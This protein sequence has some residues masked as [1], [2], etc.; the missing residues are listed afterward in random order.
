MASAVVQSN[1]VGSNA[2]GGPTGSFNATLPGSITQN[3]TITL[4]ISGD[5][6]I[7]ND[8]TASGWTQVIAHTLAGRQTNYVYTKVAGAGES[9]SVTINLTGA[10]TLYYSYY[11]EERSGLAV[12]TSY[13]VS[14]LHDDSTNS[15]TRVTGTTATTAQAAEFILT[16]ISAFHDGTTF[17]SWAALSPASGTPSALCTSVGYDSLSIGGID[18]NGTG[19]YFGTANVDGTGFPKCSAWI[20]TFL[21]ASSSVPTPGPISA[22]SQA[23]QQA[24]SW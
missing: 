18:V 9:N 21:L 5:G 2:G 11:F 13:D 4:C 23:A 14:A 17:Q 15:A 16:G 24:S 20:V 1:S 8:L 12:P 3:N 10:G 22:P 7:T 19:T 6:T